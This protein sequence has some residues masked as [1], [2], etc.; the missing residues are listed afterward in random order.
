MLKHPFGKYNFLVKSYDSDQVGKL[1]LSA[2]FH[3]LQECAWDNARLND[4]GF[5]FLKK[6][7]AFWVL[8]R[9]LVQMDEYP[10]WKDEIEIKTWPK[11]VDGFFAQRDFKIYS[12]GRIIG[13]V[14]SW[15][16]ILDRDTKRPRKPENF[17]FI[18]ESY[19]SE[20]AIERK[21]DKIIISGETKE[22]EQRKVY[23]SDLD[24]NKHVNNAT[25]V[26]WIVDS[27]YLNENKGVIT[28]FE[29]NFLLE[30]SLND[31]FTIHTINSEDGS[32]FILRNT[33][34]RDVCKARINH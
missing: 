22:L 32:Y 28:E 34:G 3:F 7:N 18:H 14:T 12:K 6:E 15:W 29:I 17:N 10:K 31:E 11:G 20:Q 33:K 8:S 21:L 30:L 26:R 5:E 23:N 19:I 27:F 16:L 9:V 25:Y 2:L 13:R 24:V 1:T 4:F